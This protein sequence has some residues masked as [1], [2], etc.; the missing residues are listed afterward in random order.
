M[1][2]QDERKVQVAAKFLSLSAEGAGGAFH[3]S[4]EQ[5]KKEGRSMMNSL[6]TV[7]LLNLRC[8]R[9]PRWVHLAGL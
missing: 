8:H 9:T 1:R 6:E 4:K 7:I 5:R 3:K 2:D